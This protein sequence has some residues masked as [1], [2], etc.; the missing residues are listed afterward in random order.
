MT[1]TE[2]AALAA[3]TT[4]TAAQDAVRRVKDGNLTHRHSPVQ[5]VEARSPHT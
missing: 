2:A 4:H 1:L 5:G 3:E